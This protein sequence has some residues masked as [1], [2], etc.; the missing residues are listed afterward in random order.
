MTV[1]IHKAE[2]DHEQVTIDQLI[3]THICCSDKARINFLI[4]FAKFQI[5]LDP[6]KYFE[7]IKGMAEQH[8]YVATLTEDHVLCQSR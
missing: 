6:D 1:N 8:D 7:Y 5:S 3:D 4:S 2:W